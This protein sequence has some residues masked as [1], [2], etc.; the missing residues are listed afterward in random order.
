MTIRAT[1]LFALVVSGALELEAGAEGA[2]WAADQ[3][4][5]RVLSLRGDRYTVGDLRA[6]FVNDDARQPIFRDRVTLDASK[7]VRAYYAVQKPTAPR[8]AGRLIDGLLRRTATGHAMIFFETSDGG[9]HSGGS[10]DGGQRF[11]G[12][13][14]SPEAR[15]REGQ[16][17]GFLSGLK[18]QERG[19]FGQIGVLSTLDERIRKSTE[20]E[21]SVVELYEVD[22]KKIDL[23]QLA[24]NAIRAAA[25]YNPT[26]S[27]NTRRNNCGT[28]CAERFEQVGGATLGGGA[29]L[30]SLIPREL[31]K[32]GWITSAKPVKVLEPSWR[33]SGGRR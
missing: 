10:A 25:G 14:Y 3:R 21:H 5:L 11:A 32:Q 23:K 8:W 27:Y 24:H 20:M 4:P 9:V 33:G 30:P 28:Q 12:L 2:R 26:E 31:W 6:G 29:W 15:L 16:R 7:V 13:V 18:P 17:Y 1:F 22:P 19:G